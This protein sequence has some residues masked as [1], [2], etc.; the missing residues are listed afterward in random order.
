MVNLWSLAFLSIGLTLLV[1]ALRLV[2]LR[3][4]ENLVCKGWLLIGIGVV[5]AIAGLVAGWRQ[6]LPSQ[7][8]T[9]LTSTSIPIVLAGGILAIQGIVE[10]KP[11]Q[12]KVLR[13]SALAPA[14][15]GLAFIAW[16]IITYIS[17]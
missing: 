4:K 7:V 10:K 5:V 3:Q 2:L 8:V 15:L 11:E 17:C 16:F 12:L 9:V 6:W 13:W 14:I 1:L